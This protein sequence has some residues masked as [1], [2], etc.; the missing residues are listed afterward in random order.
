MSFKFC[1]TQFP[2]GQEESGSYVSCWITVLLKYCQRNTVH[3]GRDIWQLSNP[4]DTAMCANVSPIIMISG[5]T[6][7]TSTPI[8]PH[9]RSSRT[10]YHQH[11]L[12][13]AYCTRVHNTAS[14]YL[15]SSCRALL[16]I[17]HVLYR[18]EHE[19]PNI[20]DEWTWY[21]NIYEAASLCIAA[22]HRCA[23][24]MSYTGMNM[25][26]QCLNSIN[27]LL[28]CCAS[29]MSYTGMNMAQQCCV[30]L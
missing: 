11:L 18:H 26:Q 15:W 1:E 24:G 13:S 14:K 12:V 30:T 20:C 8:A 22:E 23:S 4:R 16:C 9:L 5:S 28:H 27:P 3:L 25:T 6:V 19:Y 10:H 2:W 17:R 21:P 29:D 7:H